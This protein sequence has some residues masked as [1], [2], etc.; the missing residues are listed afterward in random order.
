[1][2]TTIDMMRVL[3]VVCWKIF[4]FPV[5]LCTYLLSSKSQYG[6]TTVLLREPRFRLVPPPPTVMGS[7]LFGLLFL[8]L[9]FAG[10]SSLL[11]NEML[12]QNISLK[13]GHPPESRAN[14][15]K[16]TVGVK[17]FVRPCCKC[18]VSGAR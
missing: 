6:G 8:V 14:L 4:L 5:P 9:P 1:M 18:L 3:A 17:F 10:I 16:F 13:V 2:V 11:V 12:Q 7:P 15:Y